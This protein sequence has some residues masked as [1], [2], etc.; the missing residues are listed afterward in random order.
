MQLTSFLGSLNSYSALAVVT[1][2]HY[3]GFTAILDYVKPSVT[4][5]NDLGEYKAVMHDTFDQLNNI[6]PPTRSIALRYSTFFSAEDPVKEMHN[7]IK[8]F[9][10]IDNASIKHVFLESESPDTRDKEKAVHAALMARLRNDDG[11]CESK[12]VVYKTIQAYRRDAL[13]DVNDTLNDAEFMARA[14]GLHSGI[15]LVRGSYWSPQNAH[16]F[17]AT[18]N[19]TAECYDSASD[20]IIEAFDGIPKFWLC[21]ATHNENSVN[22]ALN[23]IWTSAKNKQR[24]SFAQMSGMGDKLSYMT[25]D[26]GFETF[27]YVPIFN[28]LHCGVS[29]PRDEAPYTCSDSFEHTLRWN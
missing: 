9:C 1:R 16:V 19:D 6:T 2:L 3:K 18:A 10:A 14:Y 23:S 8:R 11:V 27:K 15:K 22:S 4:T 12:A 13:K 20:Y 26:L 28:E 29:P 7:M 25:R 24:I 5:P 21:V 17:H